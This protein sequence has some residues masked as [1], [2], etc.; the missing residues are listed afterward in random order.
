M[1]G[2]RSLGLLVLRR[3]I[4]AHCK[5]PLAS[6]FLPWNTNAIKLICF[7]LKMCENVQ[8]EQERGRETQKAAL[9]SLNACGGINIKAEPSQRKSTRWWWERGVSKHPKV[10]PL[11]GDLDR[12]RKAAPS[13]AKSGLS[14]SGVRRWGGGQGNMRGLGS[15]LLLATC[16]I[17]GKFLKVWDRKGSEKTW[18][19][20][21]LPKRCSK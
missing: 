21:A 8:G 2:G 17:W 1:T 12:Q 18:G 20:E 5:C 10:N 6:R 7:Y 9:E 11:P 14:Q 4:S 15:V 13:Q 3:T 19:G 16:W